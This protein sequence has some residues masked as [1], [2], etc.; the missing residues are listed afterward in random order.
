M[1]SLGVVHTIKRVR[2]SNSGS[3]ALSYSVGR[4]TA[5]CA[6]VTRRNDAFPALRLCRK[7]AGLAGNNE[8]D[9]GVEI[10]TLTTTVDIREW[11]GRRWGYG[12][13]RVATRALIRSV[14]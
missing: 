13:T 3:D 12:R 6:L 10:E 7:G 2:V 5:K 8:G 1:S 9:T 14:C 4:E 11:M